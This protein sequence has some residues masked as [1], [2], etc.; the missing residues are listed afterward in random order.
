MSDTAAQNAPEPQGPAKNPHD[1]TQESPPGEVHFLL[2]EE[3][4][5][6]RPEFVGR[7]GTVAEAQARAQVHSRRA[8]QPVIVRRK[9]AGSLKSVFVSAYRA[10]RR[11]YPDASGMTGGKA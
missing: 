5:V 1:H 7:A 9:E 3:H 8:Q 6:Y 10:G 11:I 4:S 2:Y